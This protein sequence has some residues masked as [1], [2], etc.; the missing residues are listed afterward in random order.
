ME[1]VVF[2]L[3]DCLDLVEGLGLPV[4]EIRATGGGARGRFWRQLQ[5]DVFGLPIHRNKIDEGPAFGAALLA[6]VACGAFETVH[7]TSE[8]VRV[9]PDV[10][11]PD[12]AAHE[13]YRKQRRVY[14]E[15]YEATAT[16]MHRLAEL[17]GP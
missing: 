5:A 12:P 10:D 17:D 8:L 6:G 7:Q 15:L 11:V 9:E 14:S 13:L 16:A 2:S 1:G 3:R 4:T